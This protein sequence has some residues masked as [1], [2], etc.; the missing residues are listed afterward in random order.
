MYLNNTTVISN[1]SPNKTQIPFTIKY[2][3]PPIA[4]YAL[5]TAGLVLHL[6]VL[7]KLCTHDPVKRRP[8]LFICLSLVNIALCVAYILGVT[9]ANRSTKNARGLQK[10][11]RQYNR[12]AMFY[13]FLLVNFITFNN[14]CR[15]RLAYRYD[16]DKMEKKWVIL[17]IFSIFFTIVL[18]ILQTKVFPPG[19]MMVFLIAVSLI[20]LINLATTYIYIMHIMVKQ[21]LEQPQVVGYFVDTNGRQRLE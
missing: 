3:G 2:I 9:L 6:A 17:I 11:R 4:V 16:E 21:R 8:I 19:V 15:I 14:F 12:G 10:I 7:K 5:S 20:L 13:H 1:T 18:T